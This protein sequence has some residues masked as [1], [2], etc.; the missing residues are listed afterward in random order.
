[1]IKAIRHTGLVV[2]DINASLTFYRDVLGLSVVKRMTE[3]GP[4]IEKVVGI[5]GA[6][7][8]WIKLKAPDGSLIELIQYH[9]ASSRSPVIE[10]AP[11]DKLGCSHIALTVRDLELCYRVLTEKG[12]R[13]NNVPQLSPDGLVKVMY[14]HDPDGIILEL[15]EEL[16]RL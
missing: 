5:P 4:F 14:C 9:S 15:V 13:C 10:N 7:L 2:R 1:M 12:L 8:E 11:S 3:S 16:H 6:V